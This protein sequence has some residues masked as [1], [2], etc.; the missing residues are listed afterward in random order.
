MTNLELLNLSTGDIIKH[1]TEPQTFVVTVNF[2]DR[3]TAV[4]TVDVTNP[5]EW[6]VVAKA[7]YR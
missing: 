1:V 4:T 2:G 6:E 3:V 7:N 5:V